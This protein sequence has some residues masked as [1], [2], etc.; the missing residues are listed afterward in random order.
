MSSWFLKTAS[1]ICVLALLALKILGA[2]LVLLPLLQS[3]IREE[4]I[5]LHS[6]SWHVGSVTATAIAGMFFY[7]LMRPGNLALSVDASLISIG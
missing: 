3:G 4:V 7:S 1:L 5:G 2:P 6:F